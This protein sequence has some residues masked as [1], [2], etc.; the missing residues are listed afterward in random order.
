MS[1]PSCRIA[2]AARN[3]TQPAAGYSAIGC[4]IKARLANFLDDFLG[5]R[6]EQQH[7]R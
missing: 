3:T 5:K 2:V 1:N 6:N 4:F 7:V